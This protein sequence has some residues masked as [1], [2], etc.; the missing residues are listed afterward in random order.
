MRRSSAHAPS[1]ASCRAAE[2]SEPGSGCSALEGYGRYNAILGASEACVTTH[3]SDL[4]VA[5][6]AV[7]HEAVGQGVG[8]LDDVALDEGL[9]TAPLGLSFF[10][11]RNQA[12]LT[13]L[14]A[15]AVIVALPIVVLYVF[16]QRHFIRGMLEGVAK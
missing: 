5:L 12:D 7:V 8:L 2:S 9:R 10:L 4:A 13:L 6:T 15:G 11:G 3:P 14:S 1:S 16:L